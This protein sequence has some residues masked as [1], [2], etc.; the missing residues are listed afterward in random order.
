MRELELSAHAR[1]RVR[2]HARLVRELLLLLRELLA[3]RVRDVSIC[4][5]TSAYASIRQHTSAYVSIRLP[6]LRVRD[7]AASRR[8]CVRARRLAVAPA[9]A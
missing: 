6:G 4:Q 5:H 9:P 1:V 8:E 3:P 2:Q 7:S